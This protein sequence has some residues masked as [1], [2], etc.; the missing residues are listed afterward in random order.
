MDID[1]Y[2]RTLGFFLHFRFLFFVTK[3]LSAAGDRAL[4]GERERRAAHEDREVHVVLELVLREDVR[5]HR[6]LPRVPGVAEH[7]PPLDRL[8]F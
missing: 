2:N 3:R 8:K 4:V 5:G 7:P 1:Q 6:V